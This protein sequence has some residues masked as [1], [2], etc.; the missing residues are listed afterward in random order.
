M[1]DNHCPKCNGNKF[2]SRRGGSRLRMIKAQ[3]IPCGKKGPAREN[4]AEA[5][6]ALCE[7]QKYKGEGYERRTEDED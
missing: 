3:C 4:Y 1:S 5:I 2:R 7:M 6:K